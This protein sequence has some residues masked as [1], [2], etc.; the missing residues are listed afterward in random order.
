VFA[1]S[2]NI[3]YFCFVQNGSVIWSNEVRSDIPSNLSSMLCHCSQQDPPVYVESC[4]RVYLCI[5]NYM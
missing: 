4:Y 3:A 2:G 5:A 1:V